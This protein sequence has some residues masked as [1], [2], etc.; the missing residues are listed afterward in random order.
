MSP[1][2]RQFGG[3]LAAVSPEVVWAVCPTGMS[4]EALRSTDG[5]A[6][7][8][9]LPTGAPNRFPVLAA[10]PRHDQCRSARCRPKLTRIIERTLC[11][12]RLLDSAGYGV[13]ATD[14]TTVRPG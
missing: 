5:G 1:C 6:H 11:V 2:L 14:L 13:V 12:N 8:S 10:V 4:A 7:W 9:V 3:A